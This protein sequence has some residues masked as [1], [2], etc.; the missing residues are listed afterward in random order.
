MS[1]PQKSHGGAAPQ[2][3]LD[4]VRAPLSLQ[5]GSNN[6]RKSN[7]NV[8]IFKENTTE[9][10][11][12]ERT[13]GLRRPRLRDLGPLPASG[14]AH[15]LLYRRIVA[16][17]PAL[18]RTLERDVI[19]LELIEELAD[20]LIVGGLHPR[21]CHRRRTGSLPARHAEEAERGLPR[22]VAGQGE[23]LA[24]EVERRGGRAGS[25]A[26]YYE[27]YLGGLNIPRSANR[28]PRPPD[29]LVTAGGMRGRRGTRRALR[30][31]SRFVS[32]EVAPVTAEPP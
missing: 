29:R 3:P 27:L 31:R 10:D 21:R 13:R 15:L 14:V 19:P 22:A 7:T 17:T 8:M 25:R 5:H 11:R 23:H 18:T 6:N 28:D 16:A 1:W 26:P 4:R 12:T 30:L 32:S 20:A 9:C 2:R 24:L